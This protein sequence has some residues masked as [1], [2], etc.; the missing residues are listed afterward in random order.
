MTT[1]WVSFVVITDNGDTLRNSIPLVLPCERKDT[2]LAIQQLSGPGKP[3]KIRAML[4]ATG[5][6]LE[7][8]I[9]FAETMKRRPTEAIRVNFGLVWRCI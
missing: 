2:I 7:I 1:G 6:V 8:S 4:N 5:I 3:L 9:M